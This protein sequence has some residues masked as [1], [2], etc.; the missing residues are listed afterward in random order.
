MGGKKEA[1]KEPKASARVKKDTQPKADGDGPS[2][3][4]TNAMI[5]HLIFYAFKNENVAEALATYR[6]MAH[7][8]KPNFYKLF[9]ADKTCKW[10]QTFSVTSENKTSTSSGAVVGDCNRYEP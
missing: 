8:D 6:S 1:P 2:R 9:K 4:E 10:I 7:G 3:P 5:G